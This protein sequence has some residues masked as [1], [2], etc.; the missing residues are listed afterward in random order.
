MEAI[1]LTSRTIVALLLIGMTANG[2][3]AGVTTT[4]S[5][6]LEGWEGPTG[7]GG[8][9]FIDNTLGNAAPS[10]RTVFNDFG[11][12]FSNSTN[13]D[14]IGDYT[15]DPSVFISIDTYTT[16]L[17]FFGIDVG[18]DFIVELRDYDNPEPG[19]PWTSVWYNLGILTASDPGWHT[20]SVT[21]ADTSA[22][23][24]PAGWG[25]YGAEDPVTFEPILP[26][27]RTFTSVLAG[28]DEIAFTTLVPGFFFGFTDHDVAVDNITLNRVP[29]PA[30]AALLF[31]GAGLLLRRRR[32]C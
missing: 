2:L 27:G 9:T 4:F 5:A 21:I 17:N 11:I 13:A 30:T 1:R 10:L 12:T 22:A 19:Y 24:L 26:A 28:V 20:W 7:V 8:A 14:F 29:E 16:F 18:R 31:L 6:G 15:T 25:G 32:S 23:A 3:Q